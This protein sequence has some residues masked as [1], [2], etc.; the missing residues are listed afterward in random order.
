[1]SAKDF[2]D[3]AQQRLAELER[4]A[5]EA[6]DP[7]ARSELAPRLEVA[8]ERLKALRLQ[9]SDVQEEALRSFAGLLDELGARVG[10][11]TA[12]RG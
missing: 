10:A 12:P 9:G 6:S 7:A 1:M 2:L 3:R 11:L 8:R 4:L 5:R